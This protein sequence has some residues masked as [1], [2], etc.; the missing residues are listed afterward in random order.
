MKGLFENKLELYF[1]WKWMFPHELRYPD[2]TLLGE[3]HLPELSGECQF[4]PIF[5]LGQRVFLFETKLDKRRAEIVLDA[6]IVS[7]AALE[8]KK[9]KKKR[10]RKK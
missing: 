5:E 4:I 6:V 1:K 7:G 8:I 2:S 10:R 3:S 9:R